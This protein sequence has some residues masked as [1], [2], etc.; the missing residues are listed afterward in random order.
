MPRF[1]FQSHLTPGVKLNMN[2]HEYK[3]TLS[4][5]P[6]KETHPATRG[7]DAHLFRSISYESTEIEYLDLLHSLVIAA[8]P[9]R[10]LETGSNI[11]VSTAA[12]AFAQKHNRDFSSEDFSVISIEIDTSLARK[13]E[14]L[15]HKLE[16][17]TLATVVVASTT[18]YLASQNQSQKYDM[19]YFD[20]SRK[21][22]IRE[23]FILKE[24]QLLN[25]DAI[26]IF[27]DTAK[28]S[29]SE[30]LENQIIQ[31]HYLEELKKIEQY[32]QGR[33]SIKLS[34]GLTIFQF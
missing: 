11:G 30:K 33:L 2:W 17:S 27:H 9:R 20:S 23:F 8:K 3:A 12:L 13:A 22:R 10:I 29:V 28:Y 32:C 15:L 16:L 25:S 19:V 21:V 24:R 1:R 26:L 5:Y 34:R 18:D 31:D 4:I 6:E 7:D 14:E